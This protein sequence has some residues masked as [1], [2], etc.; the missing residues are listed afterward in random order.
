MGGGCKE[1][2][3]SQ[4]EADSHLSALCAPISVHQ[5]WKGQGRHVEKECVQYPTASLVSPLET[6]ERDPSFCTL[7]GPHREGGRKNRWQMLGMVQNSLK[8]KGQCA[9]EQESR[10]LSSRISVF[11]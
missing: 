4:S 10:D 1:S 6:K 8:R 3:R 5:D 11:V 2:K 9:S 7:Y